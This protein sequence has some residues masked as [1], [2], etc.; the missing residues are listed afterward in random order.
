[1][2]NALRIFARIYKFRC[3]HETKQTQ[4]DV[5]RFFYS[6]AEFVFEYFRDS[7]R[8][9]ATFA[10]FCLNS[11]FATWS[12]LCPN[13][14]HVIQ[15]ALALPSISN[16]GFW[17]KKFLQNISPSP[18]CYRKILL[19]RFWCYLLTCCF[20]AVIRRPPKRKKDYEQGKVFVKFWRVKKACMGG[21]GERER[22][23]DD[24]FGIW[25]TVRSCSEKR[26]ETKLCKSR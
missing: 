25:V 6:L 1:M 7:R 12:Y 4:N 24:V 21:G 5:G 2:L 14:K 20:R 22:A 10:E 18:N 9:L 8:I 13:P 3:F 26:I 23:L 19:K 17:R 11:L 15:R 16:T